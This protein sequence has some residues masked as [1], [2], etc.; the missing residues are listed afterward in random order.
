MKYILYVV[1]VLFMVSCSQKEDL[2]QEEV[3][4]KI[5]KEEVLSEIQSKM[6]VQQNCWNTGDLDCFMQSYWK[7]D[8][9]LFLSKTGVSYGWQTTLDN[10]NETYPS[11]EK[12]GA[13]TFTN[14]IVRF[15]DNEAVQVIGKWYLTRGHRLGDLEGHYS[16]IWKFKNNDWVIISDHSS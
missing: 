13:L 2:K 9:L 1:G 8:S 6:D 7:S 4:V 10:Y 5:N 11:Q 3:M 15:I 16:L 14:I 12:R